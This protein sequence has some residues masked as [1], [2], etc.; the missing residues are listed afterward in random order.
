MYR[1]TYL[2]HGLHSLAIYSATGVYALGYMILHPWLKV[3]YRLY[4]AIWPLV[5]LTR[6]PRKNPMNDI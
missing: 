5:P 3:W 2:R 1:Q 4:A 6:L